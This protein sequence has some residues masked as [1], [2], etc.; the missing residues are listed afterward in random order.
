MSRAVDLCNDCTV[1]RTIT[2]IDIKTTQLCCSDGTCLRLEDSIQLDSG[3][4]NIRHRTTVSELSGHQIRLIPGLIQSGV[5][6]A[7]WIHRRKTDHQRSIDRETS[8]GPV[9]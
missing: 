7:I 2:R 9:R 3:G 4:A 1:G 5:A 6:F 8:F